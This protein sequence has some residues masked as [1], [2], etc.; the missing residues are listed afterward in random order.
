MIDFKNIFCLAEWKHG[1][2]HGN[3][4]VVFGD[5]KIFYGQIVNKLPTGICTYHLKD[6]CQIFC[7]FSRSPPQ[8]KPSTSQNPSETINM[9][10]LVALLPT[11][12]LIIKVEG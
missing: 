12:N 11:F 3:C 10:K 5:S 8:D 4:L 6:K 7:N 9:N 1:I 2:I